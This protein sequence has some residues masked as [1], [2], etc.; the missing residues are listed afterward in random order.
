MLIQI[1]LRRQLLI[2]AVLLLLSFSAHLWLARTGI[3]RY[4]K[5]SPAPFDLLN[6]TLQVSTTVGM[7]SCVPDN[8]PSQAVTAVHTLLIFIAMA[9]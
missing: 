1:D 9:L 8:A 4:T 7:S 6:M 2:Q 5:E 3:G